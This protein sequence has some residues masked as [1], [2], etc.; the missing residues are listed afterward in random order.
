MDAGIYE[1]L[2]MVAFGVIGMG[3]IV[4]PWLLTFTM[5]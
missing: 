3:G 2:K 1:Y 5:A 4:L